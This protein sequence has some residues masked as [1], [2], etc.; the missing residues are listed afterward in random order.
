M[1]SL[2]L[3][4]AFGHKARLQSVTKMSNYDLSSRDTVVLLFCFTW[5]PLYY[6]LSVNKPEVAQ[7]Q[8]AQDGSAMH[9]CTTVAMGKLK[10]LLAKGPGGCLKS[11]TVKSFVHRKA[12]KTNTD[13]NLCP[14]LL[15][16]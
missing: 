10:N 13:G 2:N 7:A 14:E 1:L 15:Q 9:S 4:S 6:V 8:L 11:P 3:T 16:T 5:Y 12:N